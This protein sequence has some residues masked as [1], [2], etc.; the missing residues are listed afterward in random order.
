MRMTGISF[1]YSILHTLD[2]NESKD[3]HKRQRKE[4]ENEEEVKKREALGK[5]QNIIINAQILTIIYLNLTL[6]LGTMKARARA[7]YM[8]YRE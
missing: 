8:V 1:I 3:Q 2:L 7:H 6:L 5:I 4:D